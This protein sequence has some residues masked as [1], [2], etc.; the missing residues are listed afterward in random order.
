[1]ITRLSRINWNKGVVKE[2]GT[3]YDY[4]RCEIEIDIYENSTNEFGVSTIVCELG[5]EQVHQQFLHLRGMLP[6]IVNIEFLQVKKGGSTLN[7][8]TKLDFIETCKI[9]YK[10]YEALYEKQKQSKQQ[11]TQ[12]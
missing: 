8:V 4:T 12:S 2:S 6:A 10:K 11:Q 9:D 3:P 7:Q 5:T 1:M